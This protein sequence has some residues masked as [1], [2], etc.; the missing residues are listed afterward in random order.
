MRPNEIIL[1]QGNPEKAKQLLGWLV[2]RRMSDV[3][4]E[5]CAYEQGKS[6]C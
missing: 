1:S 3:V 4:K 5:L 6:E 2:K